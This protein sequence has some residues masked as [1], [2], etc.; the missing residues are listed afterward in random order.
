MRGMTDAIRR[1]IAFAIVHSQKMVD[2][3]VARI[4][5]PLILQAWMLMAP[6]L[7][8]DRRVARMR[9]A[10]VVYANIWDY[11]TSGLI[12]QPTGHG[13]SL[14]SPVHDRDWLRFDAIM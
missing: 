6:S 7:A 13:S 10:A 9:I 14:T 1:A 4:I 3:Y 11:Q 5:G 2:R 8:G 12:W